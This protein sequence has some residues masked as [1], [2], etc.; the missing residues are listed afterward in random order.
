MSS[1]YT[2]PRPVVFLPGGVMPAAPQYEPLL[3]ALN[4]A[5]QP[6]LKDLEVYS[7]DEPPADYSMD[8]EVQ[9]LKQFAESNHLTHFDIVSYSGGAAIALAFVARYPGVATSLAMTEPAVIPS[10]EWFHDEAAKQAELK[11][12]MS[13]PP[14]DQMREFLRSHLRPGVP[15][16]PPPTGTPPPW[17]KKRP[18]GLKAMEHAFSAYDLNLQDL[19]RFAGPVYLAIGSLSDEIEERQAT[20]LQGLFPDFRCEV[21][22]GRHHFDPPQRAEPERYAR[23]LRELWTH[24]SG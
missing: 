5:V 23:A 16:P 7:G 10:Q 15:P 3:K 21:Y 4:G 22:E 1:T 11:R 9:A 18:A 14:P 19:T 8:L 2:S 6:Y 17:M 13:L 24:A 12:I 20:R